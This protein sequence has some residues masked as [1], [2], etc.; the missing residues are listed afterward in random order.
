M[1]VCRVIRFGLFFSL[2]ACLAGCA[3]IPYVD[4]PRTEEASLTFRIKVSSEP[5]DAEVYINNILY[6]RTPVE[7]PLAVICNRRKDWFEDRRE[8]KGQYILRV[9][10]KGYKN[11]A[12]PIEFHYFWCGTNNNEYLPDLKKREY[13]FKLEKEQ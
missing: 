4:P 11:A 1:E 2:A 7:F 6:G 9:S 13:D 12:E 5:K 8:V 3:S 10:K